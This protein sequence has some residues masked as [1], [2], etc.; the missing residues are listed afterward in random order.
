MYDTGS[1]K[2]CR[3]RI[4]FFKECRTKPNNLCKRHRR[5]GTLAARSKDYS[6]DG[7][8]TGL[9]GARWGVLTLGTSTNRNLP[10]LW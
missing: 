2:I 1:H 8:T 9:L 5:V 6:K 3:V 10:W 4:D 7:N